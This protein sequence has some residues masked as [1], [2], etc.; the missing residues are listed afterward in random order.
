M[1][2]DLLRALPSVDVAGVKRATGLE[3]SWTGRWLLGG[4]RGL[5]TSMVAAAG[6]LPLLVTSFPQEAWGC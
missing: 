1:V 5:P 4:G 2:R 3:A 6:R